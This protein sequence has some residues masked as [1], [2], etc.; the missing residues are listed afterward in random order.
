MIMFCGTGLVASQVYCL[1]FRVVSVMDNH[2]VKEYFMKWKTC[3]VMI[4]LGF[5][6]DFM[7]AYGY[8][9]T[10]MDPNH[11]DKPSRS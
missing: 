9:I 6:I 10:F 2:M 5:T 3:F 11:V 4:T 7:F 1:M 8:F